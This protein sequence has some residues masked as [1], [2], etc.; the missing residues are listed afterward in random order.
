MLPKTNAPRKIATENDETDTST[1]NTTAMKW[2]VCSICLEE[3]FDNDLCSHR[4]CGG[5][6]CVNCLSKMNEMHNYS[7]FLCPV[8]FLLLL[9]MVWFLSVVIYLIQCTK[10]VR[11]IPWFE[12]TFIVGIFSPTLL[13]KVI[14]PLFSVTFG[15]KEGNNDVRKASTLTVVKIMEPHF[16]VFFFFCRFVSL[17]I[18]YVEVADFKLRDVCLCDFIDVR[19]TFNLFSCF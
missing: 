10:N 11:F 4:Q 8:R 19:K 16:T 2:S 9:F 13:K 14:L 17:S 7:S 12:V 1:I 18:T 5:L 6:M 3:M 15:K